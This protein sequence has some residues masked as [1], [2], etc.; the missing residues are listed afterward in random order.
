MNS[1]I[2]KIESGSG[3]I[4]G[5]KMLCP[6][7][8]YSNDG[9]SAYFRVKVLGLVNERN[10]LMVLCAP[11]S[12]YGTFTKRADELID[13]T[14]AAIA[15]VERRKKASGLCHEI[16]ASSLITIKRRC[17]AEAYDKL[18]AS[19]KSVVDQ[20]LAARG[21][22]KIKNVTQSYIWEISRIVADLTFNV[23]REGK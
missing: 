11:A 20:E 9:E 19:K 18:P 5:M 3:S 15:E 16:N 17:L 4:K 14:K 2:K 6:I 1:L 10:E 21:I 7:I 12:G 22:G 23:K 8:R 13:D